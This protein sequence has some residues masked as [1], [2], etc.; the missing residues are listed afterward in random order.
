MDKPHNPQVHHFFIG[1]KL[2]YSIVTKRMGPWQFQHYLL[3]ARVWASGFVTK[4]VQNSSGQSIFQ[5]TSD[6]VWVLH[7]AGTHF[8]GLRKTLPRWKRCCEKGGAPIGLFGKPQV[9]HVLCLNIIF[10]NHDI[11]LTWDETMW[12]WFPLVTMIGFAQI[13]W[14]H[15]QN[16]P[17]FVYSPCSDSNIILL[18]LYPAW[19]TPSHPCFKTISWCFESN[20]H[21]KATLVHSWCSWMFIPPWYGN[22][23]GNLTHPLS[24]VA[25]NN[26]PQRGPRN[27]RSKTPE[28]SQLPPNS[29]WYT[30]R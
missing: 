9:V 20:P 18:V 5:R 24:E 7:F 28:T 2:G 22:F 1:H 12:G 30:L 29:C 23:I 17:F 13:L 10:V 26:F 19:K 14:E 25:R 16:P 8:H 21:P 3:V 15:T 11:S 6:F 27:A 4:W